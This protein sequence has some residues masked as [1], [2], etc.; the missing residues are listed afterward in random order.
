MVTKTNV[1]ISP[2]E[3]SF[4]AMIANIMHFFKN[5][6]NMSFNGINCRSSKNCDIFLFRFIRLIEF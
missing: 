3:C 2:T 6:P 1:I 4:L 5:I